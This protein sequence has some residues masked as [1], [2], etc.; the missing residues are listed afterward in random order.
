M[1]LVL[2]RNLCGTFCFSM[3]FVVFMDLIG[4]VVL[5]IA[6]TLTYTLAV[7]MAINPPNTFEEAIPLMLLSAVLGLPAILIL[8][9]TRKV[10]YVFWMM[11]YLI[12]LPIW[13]FILPVYAF[14]HFDDFS[15]GETRYVCTVRSSICLRAKVSQF[16]ER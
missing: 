1:E 9:T 7:G 4:T 15:W 14:W 10:V 12:A 6:I 11:V 3:Q 16:T 5:P 8:L 13:N 2:V